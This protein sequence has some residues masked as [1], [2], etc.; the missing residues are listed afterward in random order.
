MVLYRD[1]PRA[2]S[3]SGLPPY[4]VERVRA[5]AS[6]TMMKEEK[7]DVDILS[8]A[9]ISVMNAALTNMDLLETF[10]TRRVQPLQAQAHR[11]WMYE[12]PSDP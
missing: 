3:Q 9:L 2:N 10:L 7:V 11:M 1:V 5:L 8:S 12:G 4:S 6:L